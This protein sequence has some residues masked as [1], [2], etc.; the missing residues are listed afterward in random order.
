MADKPYRT[1]TTIAGQHIFSPRFDRKADLREWLEV[2]SNARKNL[3]DG[4]DLTAQQRAVLTSAGFQ[5]QMQQGDMFV[6]SLAAKFLV[7]RAEEYVSSTSMPNFDHLRKYILPV[8]GERNVY[9]ISPAEIN[10]FLKGLKEKKYLGRDEDGN[11]RYDDTAKPLS[12]STKNKIKVTLSLLFD[13]AI[14]EELVGDNFVN[15]VQKTRR[16][17]SRKASAD[18]KTK[19]KIF[20]TAKQIQSFLTACNEIG[21]MFLAF[22]TTKINT[23]GRKSELLGLTW[24]D[25]DSENSRIHIGK[26]LEQCSGIVALRTKSGADKARYVPMN[27][28]VHECLLSWKSVSK[29]TKQKDYVFCR[30]DGRPFSPRDIVDLFAKACIEAKVPNI[31]PHGLRHTYATHYMINGGKVEELK[32]LLGHSTITT[33]M[34]YVHL[35]K[36]LSK[37]KDRTVS[38]KFERSPDDSE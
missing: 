35:A 38:F 36:M 13:Y 6:K 30:D 1:H 21:P 9:G 25:V 3:R 28:W 24:N 4:K 23:G 15:P 18:E 27:E 14:E 29:Y 2:V 33:T 7:M 11:H 16:R 26:I 32:E 17:G 10:R 19:T 20:E 34:K 31:G 5:F 8:M 12:D 22:S 37:G